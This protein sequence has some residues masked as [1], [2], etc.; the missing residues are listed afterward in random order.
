MEITFI[1]YQIVKK[2]A[3]IKCSERF[4]QLWVEQKF[5]KMV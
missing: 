5:N 2:R 3:L 4:N 1:A